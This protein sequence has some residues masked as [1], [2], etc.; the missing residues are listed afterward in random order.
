MSEGR[1]SFGKRGEVVDKSV[2][3]RPSV[4]D[5]FDEKDASIISDI[6]E[7]MTKDWKHIFLTVMGCF[8][9]YLVISSVVVEASKSPEQRAAE[10]AEKEKVAQAAAYEKACGSKN[11]GMAFVMMQKPIRSRLRSPSSASF[12]YQ[13]DAIAPIGNCRFKMVSYVDAQ[14]GFGATLRTRWSGTIQFNPDD[15]TWRA[16]EVNVGG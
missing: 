9:A 6:I 15:N 13:P 8:A 2:Q 1:G 16:I 10:K 14:N 7:F 4:E 11:N 3:T 12:P 5:I